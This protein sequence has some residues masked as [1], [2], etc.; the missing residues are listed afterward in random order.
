[1]N[2]VSDLPDFTISA[3]TNFLE[4]EEILSDL[5]DLPSLDFILVS[6]LLVE[7]LLID[8]VMTDESIPFFFWNTFRIR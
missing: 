5:E 4:E 6:V 1:M 7:F 2:I 8:F 3:A